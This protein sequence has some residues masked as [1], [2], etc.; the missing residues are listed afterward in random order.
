MSDQ[1]VFQPSAAAIARTHVKKNQ[2]D[3]MYARSVSDP[4]G[5]W[6]DQAKRLDWVR[7]PTTIK[8]TTFQYPN[9]SIKW[10]ED[11]VLNVAA[12]CIDRHLAE[13]GDDIAIIWE[14]DDPNAQA[15][16]ISYRTLHEKVCR[17]ANV[18]KSLGV[19]KG[20]RVTIYLPMIPQ[21]AYAMLACARIGAVHSVVFAGFSPDALA[22]RINDC[23]SHI[24]ITADEG[25][26]GGKTVP[27]KKNVD[28]ALQDAPGVE[29]VLV[30]KNTG[31]DVA[32][33][34]S[35]D[36]WWH[37]AAAG[38]EPFCDP[39]PM[40]AEDPLF[41]LYTSGSTGKPKGV[42]HTTGGYI[43]WTSLTHQL[44][45]DY[46]D[47]EVFWCTAD[48][49]WVTGHS[50]IVYGPLANG[51]TTL[52]FEGVPSYPDAG[53]FWDVVDKHKVNIF[54]TAPTA[55]R[56]LMGAG[57]EWDDKHDLSSLRLIGSVGE[58]INPE[59]WLWYHKHVGKGRCEIVDTWW[60]TETGGHMIC[61]FPGAFPTKPG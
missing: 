5:F 42:V 22:G 14:P 49:G 6:A 39:E 3:E 37:E 24:V 12:N 11:G 60:Q 32:M 50:Y 17:C 4:D 58:P 51:A 61:P 52:M 43:V 23:D 18:L 26:R 28:A 48:I 2:Y 35:R 54:H 59:A 38:V 30:V 19:R 21:A 20:D 46:R 41:V 9:V 36:V 47:G 8:N 57:S 10:F 27:L 16:H 40:N 44:T 45:F 15:E 31:N 34:G 29:K 33:K 13:H 7:F 53:R 25:R 56:A 55:I 1:L